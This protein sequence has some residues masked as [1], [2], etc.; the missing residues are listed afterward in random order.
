MKGR[1]LELTATLAVAAASLLLI[2]AGTDRIP[3]T[4]A[5]Q[6][7]VGQI[8]S[9]D[10]ATYGRVALEMVFGG[11]WL[12]PHILGGLFLYKPPLLYWLSALPWKLLVFS[13]LSSR[14]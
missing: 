10:E 5:Y 1:P 7:R 8:R 13:R 11:D 9:Q 14:L 6:D 4:A 12:T 2:T 3:M